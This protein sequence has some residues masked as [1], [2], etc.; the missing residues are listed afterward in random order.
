MPSSRM[1]IGFIPPKP[2]R[3]AIKRAAINYIKEVEF[4]SM[5]DKFDEN[6]KKV[7][8]I[9]IFDRLGPHK[10]HKRNYKQR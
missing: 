8:R 7:Q 2:V 5:N 4:S 3:I 10:K 9:S 6:G 1:G